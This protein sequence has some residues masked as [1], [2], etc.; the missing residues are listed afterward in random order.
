[1]TK[2]VEKDSIVREKIIDISHEGKGII[3]VD[4][5]TV[6]VKDGLID[7]IVDVKITKAKK[8]Y[9]FGEIL[10]IVEES[11][12]RIKS[13]CKVS[14][15]CGGCQ[16]QELEY[17]K[18][19]EYKEEKV[20][21]NLIRIGEIENPNINKIIGM[22]EPYRYR[23]NVQLPV[24]SYKKEPIIGYYKKGSKYIVDTD[25]CLIQNEIADRAIEVLRDFM[26]KNSIEGYNERNNTGIIKHLVVRTAEKTK[27]TMI[28]LVVNKKLPKADELV[29][30]FLEKIKEIKTIIVNI[31]KEDNT[32]LYGNKSEILYGD[33]YIEDT[34]G[35]LKFNISPKSFFQVNSVQTEKLYGKVK[36]YLNL[37]GD[38]VLI[39]LYCGIGTIGM[40]LSDSCKKIIGVEFVKESIEDGKKNLILNNINNMEFIEGLAEDILPKLV[41][42]NIKIDALVVDPP[43]KGLDEKVVE[44]ILKLKPKKLVYVS[45]DPAT[46]ARDLK[47]LKDNYNI[48]EVQ[49][50]DMFPMGVHVESLTL[51][52]RD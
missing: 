7:D 22:E 39:D 40:Y 50:V 24:G 11:K 21:N 6:F 16:F 28:V 19:L 5:Y 38:E 43:R 3:K 42:E 29:K 36:E 48:K 18:Q 49:P 26:K 37:N 41:E 25:I 20:K 32:L 1:M 9:G 10:N 34:V 30:I 44:A 51:L 2:P 12:Y 14:N 4:G 15:E 45:C 33:G 13:K 46:L 31:N 23:N 17:K 8:N 35:E 52:M 27:D 47:I